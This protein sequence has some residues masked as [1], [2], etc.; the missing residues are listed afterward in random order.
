MR[1][2]L[3]YNSIITKYFNLDG[4]VL[5]P[6]ILI[7]EKKENTTIITLK[8]ELIHIEQIKRYGVFYF[9]YKYLTYILKFWNETDDITRG[10]I[11]NEFEE[12]AYSRENEPL[13]K[14]ELLLIN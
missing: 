10:F 7:S 13:T 3:I 4:L 12:E 1:P 8:H 14:E 2:I 11:E 6:F 5:Y 9:Y